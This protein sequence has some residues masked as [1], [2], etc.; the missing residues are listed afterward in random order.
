VQKIAASGPGDRENS[1][2]VGKNPGVDFKIQPTPV[3]GLPLSS[4]GLTG[5][6]FASLENDLDLALKSGGVEYRQ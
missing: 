4:F 6:S 3:L 5:I 2:K 1:N